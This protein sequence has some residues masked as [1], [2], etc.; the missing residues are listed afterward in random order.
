MNKP[1]IDSMRRK[2]IKKL[3]F[4]YCAF[5]Q[6]KNIQRSIPKGIV[7]I[8]VTCLECGSVGAVE[9]MPKGHYVTTWS[10]PHLSPAD[11]PQ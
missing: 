5:C 2:A 1:E 7:G 8:Y 9:E 3:D 11:T 4:G 6:S 10:L